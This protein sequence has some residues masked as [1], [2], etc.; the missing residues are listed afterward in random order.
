M[1]DEALGDRATTSSDTSERE[2]LLDEISR[3]EQSFRRAKDRWNRRY[4]GT[5]LGSVLASAS[6]ALVL[7]LETITGEWK[8]DLA[9]VL[10]TSAAVLTSAMHVGG[11]ERRWRA[12]RRAR[13]TIHQLRLQ[14]LDSDADLKSVNHGL[15]DAIAEY[16][17]D[18]SGAGVGAGQ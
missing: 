7:K 2:L 3:L 16:D 15:R 11:F 5:L 4:Y 10:A 13:S 18:A 14:M 1:T 12:A 6:A 8:V 17:R 9:A